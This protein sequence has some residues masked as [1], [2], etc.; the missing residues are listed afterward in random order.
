MLGN[1]LE[2]VRTNAPLVHNI[3]N[4]VTVN[5]CANIL[6]A[7]GGSPIMSDDLEEVEEITAL[8][9]SLNINIGT[10]NGRTIPA[11]FAAGKQANAC[12]RPVLL[13]PV[14]AGASRLRTV[15][16]LQLLEQVRCSAI[17]GNVSEMKTLAQ[18]SGSTKGVDADAVD[19]VTEQNLGEA[20]AFAKG[21][22]ARTGA[23][24][25]MTGAIDIVADSR[26]AYIIR[27]GHPL[28][29]RITG[30]GCMLS[31]MTAAYLAANPR[32]PLAAVAAAVV[33]MGLAGELAATRLRE[34][35]GNSTYRHHL[36]DA[37]YGLNGEALEK[38]A[39]YEVR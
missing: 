38:G 8:C 7:A 4:Y 13:D 19:A 30:G 5:D 15:T 16:A 26:E 6:L 2:N 29:G 18:G 10:L 33:A 9:G 31:A 35:E 36:I 23:V 20:T 25:A 24:I 22:A 21:F 34:G 37:V 39:R 1:L 12:G 17:R 14:G 3:T 11:M 28:M 27:N 32:Q